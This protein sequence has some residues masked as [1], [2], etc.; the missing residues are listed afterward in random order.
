MMTTDQ[1]NLSQEYQAM[2]AQVAAQISGFHYFATL[3]EAVRREQIGN[4]IDYLDRARNAGSDG[5]AQMLGEELGLEQIAETFEPFAVARDG[6]TVTLNEGGELIEAAY[7]LTNRLFSEDDLWNNITPDRARRIGDQTAA[8]IR[9]YDASLQ[10]R[11]T[12]GIS[13]ASNADIFGAIGSFFSAS[14]EY[15]GQY[16]SWALG[17]FEADFAWQSFN[18]IW[19]ENETVAVARNEIDIARGRAQAVR[20]GLQEQYG[21]QA[22]IAQLVSGL[23]ENNK[24][25]DIPGFVTT[26][27]P[28]TLKAIHAEITDNHPSLMQQL[29]QIGQG[30]DT[31]SLMIGG[32]IAAMGVSAAYGAVERP[33]RGA[34]NLAI[35]MAEGLGSTR[36][37]GTAVSSASTAI[38]R[39]ISTPLEWN[40]ARGAYADPIATG[41]SRAAQSAP[42]AL[43]TAGRAI[44]RK[45]P[46]AGA[47]L[48]IAWNLDYLNA[49]SEAE[50]NSQNP[51]SPED[52]ETLRQILAVDSI[53]A[54]GGFLA[55]GAN[56]GLRH[57]I[58]DSDKLQ[59]WIDQGLIPPT[60]AGMAYELATADRE[61]IEHV[62]E[63]YESLQ[64][65]VGSVPLERDA[66]VG[67][68]IDASRN[69]ISILETWHRY[70]V[71]VQQFG[72][73]ENPLDNHPYIQAAKAVFERQP[74]RQRG[75]TFFEFA[76]T[77]LRS[78]PRSD[79][80]IRYQMTEAE[81]ASVG[82][83][84]PSNPQAGLAVNE[85]QLY[86]DLM[87]Q[88]P[89]Y[90][91]LMQCSIAAGQSLADF[92]RRVMHT[93]N[94]LS[95][96][97]A[98]HDSMQKNMAIVRAD[99]FGLD[100]PIIRPVTEEEATAY[101]AMNQQ[102]QEAEE[103]FFVNTPAVAPGIAERMLRMVQEHERM[104]RTGMQRYAQTYFEDVLLN[105]PVESLRVKHLSA[106]V[107]F[108]RTDA[109]NL[110]RQS[111]FFE[112]L[113][114]SRF[115][116]DFA[117]EM[118]DSVDSGKMTATMRRALEEYKA[119]LGGD[120]AAYGK[121]IDQRNALLADAMLID[122]R[123]DN[124]LLI[125]H[126]NI[127]TVT[128]AL[129]LAYTMPD[130]ES[131]REAIESGEIS[132]E[133]AQIITSAADLRK[134]FELAEKEAVTATITD[135]QRDFYRQMNRF[136]RTVDSNY[137]ENPQA[138]AQQ[139]G[140]EEH[141]MLTKDA[142]TEIALAIAT[143][144]AGP[145][146]RLEAPT[147]VA[148]NTVK[149]DVADV[150]SAARIVPSQVAAVV[151]VP[152]VAQQLRFNA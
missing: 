131:V 18:D 72:A 66:L 85:A 148:A 106:A 81:R 25:F 108:Q 151:D 13:A 141:A 91:R 139:R 47:I 71:D 115:K 39:A 17:G 90:A 112:W 46:V 152:P 144:Q 123:T 6:L 8:L 107:A 127:E 30:R 145:L 111:V 113:D 67:R 64:N 82:L 93:L 83:F 80:F 89:L 22:D 149:L 29:E 43:R 41:A 100:D 26:D 11:V 105:N 68:G 125:A 56:E 21:H 126:Q 50:T 12:S 10:G 7:G 74:N 40:L 61:Q 75:H 2:A 118:R 15:L 92:E 9:E 73:K 121:H 120:S 31:A 77:Q 57:A 53:A 45:I 143:A 52:A 135:V 102:G 119:Y 78:V 79:A 147:T 60:L 150:D 59:N 5:I 3:P 70:Q 109:E 129:R 97:N 146:T 96:G 95:S 1:E 98:N 38:T 104:M 116:Q 58:A 136:M 44:G 48:A 142:G 137:Y 34:A 24:F 128:D 99:W 87:E 134:A 36:V 20:D 54:L 35:G 86:V 28:E 55:D 69:T 117:A 122:A 51:L 140:E 19:S 84:D 101:I 103:G 27:N 88:G 94:E 49:V 76:A 114:N 33:F 138:I 133:M 110:G 62:Q 124:I 4:V 16:V 14:A 42:T 132:P 32:T 65:H 37:V 23:D 130:V 63:L